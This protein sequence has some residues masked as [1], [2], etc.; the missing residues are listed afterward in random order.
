MTRNS[1]SWLLSVSLLAACAGEEPEPLPRAEVTRARIERV[2]IATG[3]V[4]PA[5]EV[6][7][8]PRIAGI[9][10]KIHVSEGDLV[11][12]GQALVEIER[13]LLASRVREAEASLEAARVEQ[14]FARIALERERK[15]GANG[16]SSD[17][18]LDEA[19]ARYERGRA[20]TSRAQA[21]LDTLSTQLGY[22]TL[23]SSLVGRVLEVHE[24]VGTAVSAVTSVTGGTLVLSI[25][26]DEVMHL[27]GLVDEN[28]VARISLGLPAR[29][30]TEA[31]PE[32]VFAGTVREIAPLGQRVQNV[33]YF[34]V[35]VEIT[36][37]DA[38]VLRPRMSGDAEIIAEVV[39]DAVVVPETALRYRG[40]DIYVVVPGAGDETE[41]RIVELGIIDGA[42]V[43]V[44]GGVE[45]GEEVLLQ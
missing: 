29:I 2:V 16:A 44:L 25:A 27:E 5:T 7:V 42:R 37:V 9:I 28:E 4:E 18:K 22:A 13:E 30:R 23:R 21:A 34:E 43:Q 14:R 24:E 3:T 17:R 33:T 15:M 45:P 11:E 36:D 31:Y 1:L 6:A 12:V 39:E 10:E 19:L 26:G 32:R 8:R 41:E 40:E 35:K 20:A 38:G